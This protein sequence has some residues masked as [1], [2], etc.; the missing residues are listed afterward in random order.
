MDSAVRV[1]SKR[2]VYQIS[3]LQNAEK[4]EAAA[5]KGQIFCLML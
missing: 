1:K 5:S 4:R 3:Q 2:Q